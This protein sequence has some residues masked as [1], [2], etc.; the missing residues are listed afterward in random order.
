V[1]VKVAWG[2][3]SFASPAW[4]EKYTRNSTRSDWSLRLLDDEGEGGLGRLLIGFARLALEIHPQLDAA[5]LVDAVTG[6]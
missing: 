1:K 5:R 2:A 4:R 6:Q 3:W